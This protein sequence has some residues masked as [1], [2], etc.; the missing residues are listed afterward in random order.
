MESKVNVILKRRYEKD[1]MYASIVYICPNYK[2]CKE[3]FF[4]CR[5]GYTDMESCD[6][7]FVS[8]I[9]Y[10]DNIRR[11]NYTFKDMCSFIRAHNAFC[12]HKSE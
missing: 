3:G 1:G 9:D 7:P 4:V 11:I 8:Q 5:L 10:D 12:H 2:S 6:L